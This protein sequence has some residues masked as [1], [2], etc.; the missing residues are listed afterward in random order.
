M[1]SVITPAQYIKPKFSTKNTLITLSIALATFS[2]TGCQTPKGTAST[3]A[4]LSQLP[5]T[6]SS[7]AHHLMQQTMLH[8][9]DKSYTF[10]KITQYQAVP[11]YNDQ[12]IE[13]SH[14][15]LFNLMFNGFYGHSSKYGSDKNRPL[16]KEQQ[17]CEDRYNEAFEK[18]LDDFSDELIDEK[19]LTEQQTQEQASYE[20]CVANAP[21]YTPSKKQNTAKSKPLAAG[22][23]ATITEE[24]PQAK[25][26]EDFREAMQKT[27]EKLD[28]LEARQAKAEKKKP[29]SGGYSSRRFGMA[30]FLG[31]LKITPEQID[32]VNQ[33]FLQNQTLRYSGFYDQ[34]K[35]QFSTVLEENRGRLGVE[36]YRRVPVLLDLHNMSLTLEPDVALPFAGIM[37]DKQ[38]PDNIA[39]KSVKFTLPAN[40]RQN[41]PLPVLKDSLI[42]SIGQAYGDIDAE[43]FNEVVLDDYARSLHASRVVKINMGIQDMGFLFAR[44]VKYWVADLN[45]IALQHPEYIQNNQ[46]FKLALDL[47]TK[48]NR[49]Y[50]ADDVAHLAKI[51]EAFLPVNF[52]DYNYYYFDRQNNLIGYRKSRDYSSGLL[53]G[54][55]VATTVNTIRYQPASNNPLFYQPKAEDTLDGNALIDS[56]INDKKLE[57]VAK[58]ARFEYDMSGETTDTESGKDNENRH[59]QTAAERAAEAAEAAATE[60]KNLADE[61]DQEA[62]PTEA[63]DDSENES[64]ADEDY[65]RGSNRTPSYHLPSHMESDE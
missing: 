56:V 16:S 47:F 5:A 41:I 31:N 45:Q 17:A 49:H 52:N 26:Q 64:E 24:N 58:D 36:N 20:S 60:A 42:K 30:G 62:E 38:L 40:L 65:Q 33:S 25:R 9:F 8:R 14:D 48:L 32:V 4:H 13:A 11:M 6:S 61:E 59:D 10:D 34:N 29:R 35:G 37:F 23:E 57:A 2:I 12:D 15:S 1:N 63:N 7:N 55:L 19:Q 43:K 50:R 27:I 44:S 3:P 51:V 28:E 54:K 46:D 53:N 22:D 18:T 21:A 39:G